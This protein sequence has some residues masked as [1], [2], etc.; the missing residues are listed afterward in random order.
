MF[1]MLYMC[2][3]I[4]IYDIQVNHMIT[5]STAFIGNINFCEISHLENCNRKTGWAC[6]SFFQIVYFV[7]FVPLKE[8]ID[9]RERRPVLELDVFLLFFKLFVPFCSFLR[10]NSRVSQERDARSLSW[11]CFSFFFNRLFHS[12]RSCVKTIVSQ[13]RRPVLE[14]DVFLLF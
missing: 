7:L 13:E 9:S 11:A 3:F 4:Q 14:L 10:K 5:N 1:Y 8:R 6:F 12:V 2:V